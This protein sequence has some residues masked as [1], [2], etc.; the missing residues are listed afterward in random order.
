MNLV[1][2][3]KL[4]SQLVAADFCSVS[5]VNKISDGEEVS[6]GG[7]HVEDVGC[8][9]AHVEDFGFGGENVGSG[10]DFGSGGENVGSGA[11]V[12]GCVGFDTSLRF[13]TALG[14]DTAFG[15]VGFGCGVNFL[16]V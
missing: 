10:E 1:L 8:G 3:G 16:L 14:F 7:E 5:C 12:F 6:S 9:G 13:D 15:C 2:E 4:V 11:E